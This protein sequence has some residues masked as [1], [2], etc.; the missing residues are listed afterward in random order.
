MEQEL[1]STG[2]DAAVSDPVLRMTSCG[3]VPVVLLPDADAALPLAEALLEGGIDVIE[4]TLRNE[5]GLAGIEQVARHLP[6][7]VVIAG[8]VLNPR[9]MQQVKDAGAHCAV[10]PGF[11]QEVALAATA[12]GMPW[13]P[14]VATASDCMR[15]LATGRSL[16]KFF[17]AEQAGGPAMVK[18]LGG[19]YPGLSFCPTGGVSLANMADYFAVTSV[20]MVGGSWIAPID[21]VKAKQWSTIAAHAKGAVA[22]VTALRHIP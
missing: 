4:I 9:Q 18:A 5:S 1:M 21:L 22:A 11:T 15:V 6:G 7:M 12:L 17:P 3:V 14:G 20:R 10:S 2:M 13:L 19:P 16:A 8:T